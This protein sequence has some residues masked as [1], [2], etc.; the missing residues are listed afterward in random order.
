MKRFVTYIALLL[1]ILVLLAF[2]LDAL[3]TKVYNTG[4]YRNKIMW[5][6]EMEG[7]AVDYILLGSSRMN[8]HIDPTQIK[9]ETGKDGFNLGV[10]AFSI[11]ESHLML[12]EFLKKNTTK[13][14]IVQVDS[15]YRQTKP[16]PIGEKSWLP[17]IYEPY[18]YEEFESYG[19]E[20]KLYKHIPF[21]RFQKFESRIGYRDVITS[22]LGKGHV[23][24][25]LSG[26]DPR[27][28]VLKRELTYREDKPIVQENTSSKKMI[29][30]CKKHNIKLIFVTAPIYKFKGDLAPLR[31]YLPNYHDF[32]DSIRQRELFSDQIHLNAKGAELFTGQIIDAFF[33]REL[34]KGKNTIIQDTLQ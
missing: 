10:N 8:N 13:M 11:F 31:Q 29:E 23:Y 1:G 15:R 22:A 26:F 2:L 3:Y 9:R 19:T 14:V 17:F 7:E 33:E 32:K 5:V 27:S 16:D 6:R 25:K 34:P 18:V 24:N 12:K 28:Q 21:Y 4:A 30:L 20:Y